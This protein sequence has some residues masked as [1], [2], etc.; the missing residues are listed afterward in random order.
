MN[1]TTTLNAP[2][3][4]GIEYLPVIR[5]CPTGISTGDQRTRCFPDTISESDVTD[6]VTSIPGT[7]WFIGNEPDRPDHLLTGQDATE[8]ALYAQHY[9]D[10]Y[11]IIK[12]ADPTASVLAGSIVQPTE[13][14]IKYLDLILAAYREQYGAP[15]PVD[16]WSIH[17]YVLN[18]RSCDHFSVYECWGADIPPGV[19]DISGLVIDAQQ[20]DDFS[21]FVAQI[22]RFRAWMAQNGYRNTPLFLSEFGVL[23]PEGI[24]FDPDFTPARV[25]TFMNKTFDYL[26]SKTDAAVGYPADGNRLVQRFSW[27]STT[28][29]NFNGRLFEPDTKQLTAIGT[30]FANY[31]APIALEADFYPIRLSTQPTIPMS[32][33][34]PISVTLQADIANS[35][36]TL[37]AYDVRVQFYQGDPE[38]GGVQIGSD[39]IVSLAGCGDTQT[40]SVIWETAPV[41][42]T[43]IYVKVSPVNPATA[44]E[45]S[46]AG[47][48]N[49][50]M[51]SL[52]VGTETTYL[53]L[54]D[55]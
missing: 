18:E 1:F 45:S 9:H 10:L 36:N 17:N 53:P 6:W 32:S 35:G 43:P 19:S 44:P 37:T 27:Y 39:Q 15:M 47:A 40:A 2:R 23:M 55:R 34:D 33:G 14:R 11:Q 22:E 31:V 26:R 5:V 52:S 50:S 49:V 41:G 16:G 51:Y 42:V 25:N 3:P 46:E 21:L 8:P 4:N 28:D 29:N 13:V 38:D 24:G 54:I 20:N 12:A 48:N 7:H 30:N